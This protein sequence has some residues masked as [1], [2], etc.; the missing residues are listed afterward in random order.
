MDERHAKQGSATTKDS[1]IRLAEAIIDDAFASMV[2][3]SRDEVAAKE[4]AAAAAKRNLAVVLA[5]QS[6]WNRA[7]TFDHV[8]GFRAV[9]LAQVAHLAETSLPACIHL[10]ALTAYLSEFHPADEP[11]RPE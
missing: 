7:G 9:V 2:V 10:R 1:D 6:A 8:V 3:E 5:Q 4:G 11:R